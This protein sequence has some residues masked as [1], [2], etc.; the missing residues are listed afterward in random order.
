MGNLI[1]KF[2]Y[3][4]NAVGDSIEASADKALALL[5]RVE[6]RSFTSGSSNLAQIKDEH[7]FDMK[8]LLAIARGSY[9][10]AEVTAIGEKFRMIAARSKTEAWRWLLTRSLWLYSVPNGSQAHVNGPA[11]ELG[12]RFNF[13]DL[14][15]RLCVRL[16]ALPAPANT[17][18]FDELLAVLNDDASWSLTGE[19]FYDQYMSKRSELGIADPA[20]HSILLETQGK[21]N[22]E[23]KYGVRRDNMNRI[24]A[25]FYLQTGFFSR[26]ECAAGFVGIYLDPEVYAESVLARR[27]RFVLDNPREHVES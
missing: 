7:F 3:P 12:I 18:Y 19:A 11:R 17:L 26:R 2:T 24:F 1:Q 9:G 27:L 25:K 6:T 14:T 16:S 22:L 20:D 23:G 4:R 15:T 8:H 21:P 10:D 5:V 13:F